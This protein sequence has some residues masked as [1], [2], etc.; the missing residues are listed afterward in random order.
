MKFFTLAKA[1]EMS[2]NEIVFLSDVSGDDRIFSV[3]DVPA[4]SL[5]EVL[6]IRSQARDLHLEIKDATGV[7]EVAAL[8]WHKF[9]IYTP[10]TIAA[11]NLSVGDKILLRGNHT[12]PDLNDSDSRPSCISEV[13]EVSQNSKS[14]IEVLLRL[15][16][17]IERKFR[18][19]N[20]ELPIQRRPLTDVLMTFP[21]DA[22]IEISHGG[23][24]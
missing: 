11:K 17:P 22:K 19:G 14:E 4:F 9:A 24:A 7:Y 13:K 12:L 23:Y 8:P 1:S 20:L 6:S 16:T 2:P 5:G 10:D 15:S 21:I 3:A 18:F